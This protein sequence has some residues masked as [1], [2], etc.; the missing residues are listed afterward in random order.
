MTCR[1]NKVMHI[2][3]CMYIHTNPC[4]YIHTYIHIY[5]R[6]YIHINYP[7]HIR[8]KIPLESDKIKCHKLKHCTKKCFEHE[9][10]IFQGSCMHF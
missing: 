10:K 6:T 2:F 5:I 9:N 7:I 8:Q 3:I 1:D 4:I